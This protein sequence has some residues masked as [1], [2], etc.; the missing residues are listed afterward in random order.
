MET[1]QPRMMNVV[2]N[3]HPSMRRRPPPP[4]DASSILKEMGESEEDLHGVVF[5]GKNAT[6][7]ESSN[8]SDSSSNTMIIII[9]ALVVV[10]LVALV[11]WMVT[12]NNEPSSSDAEFRAQ[13]QAQARQNQSALAQQQAMYNQQAHRARAQQM[14]TQQAN[15]NLINGQTPTLG[16]QFAPENLHNTHNQAQSMHSQPHTQQV[17]PVNGQPHTHN[18]V[19]NSKQ[20]SFAEPLVSDPG[21]ERERRKREVSEIQR[22]AQ[23][24]LAE[25]TEN[26][27]TDDDKNMIDTFNDINIDEDDTN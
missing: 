7:E 10:A 18:Q 5:N 27:L 26:A 16:P 9:F 3:V 13:L 4:K 17:Q 24:A 1:E 20:V 21:E 23:A 19:E 22:M 8:N 2:P 15:G 14:A 11:V 25:D 6:K 12:K